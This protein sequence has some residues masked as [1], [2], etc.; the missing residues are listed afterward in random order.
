MLPAALLAAGS[1]RAARIGTLSATG[2][3][4]PRS[5]PAPL[6]PP[7]RD[8]LGSPT[9]RTRHP[10]LHSP[11]HSPLHR[12]DKTTLHSSLVLS[13]H[14]PSLPLPSPPSLPSSTRTIIHTIHDSLVSLPLPPSTPLPSPPPL[15]SLFALTSH[16]CV[17]QRVSQARCNLAKRPSC[18]SWRS[19]LA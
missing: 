19:F 8:P 17:F 11:L 12:Q 16:P 7:A 13:A 1:P 10:P 5:S 18:C 15:I 6:Q 3:E 14:T 4:T 9:R 2:G